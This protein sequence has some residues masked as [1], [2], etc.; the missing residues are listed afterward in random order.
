MKAS[1][2]LIIDDDKGF[3]SM[4][5]LFL[6]SK[7]EF[8]VACES[9][10][11]QALQSAREQKP[12]LILLD[13]VM[14]HLDGGDVHAMLSADSMLGR[15]PVIFLTS[16]VSQEDNSEDP[17]VRSGGNVMLPKTT[18]PDQLMTCIQQKIS[19]QI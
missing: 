18:P 9:D 1:Q 19:G 5:K 8:E 15:V 10:S 4:T 13:I 16:M 6:E 14:P 12:D 7:G 11:R 3:A 17:Y 2:I